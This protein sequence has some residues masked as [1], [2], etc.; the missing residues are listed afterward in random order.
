MHDILLPS[1]RL[2]R[3]RN[4]YRFPDEAALVARV[5]LIGRRVPMR[6]YWR[7][8]PVHLRELPRQMVISGVGPMSERVGEVRDALPPPPSIRS[9]GARGLRR[10]SATAAVAV[11]AAREASSAGASK[12]ASLPSSMPAM[13]AIMRDEGG[14]ALAVSTRTRIRRGVLHRWPIIISAIAGALAAYYAD[15]S[16]GRRRRALMRDR[17]AHMRNVVT[18]TIPRRIE[19]RARFFGGVARGIRHETADFVLHDGHHEQVD[20]DTLV[21]RVRSEAL[22]SGTIKSG[23]INV[24][25]YEGCVTLRGQLEHPGNIRRLVEAVRRVEGVR[26]VRSYLHLPGTLPP[27]KAE[28]Y[29]YA[30]GPLA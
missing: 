8:R 6:G 23:E 26:E 3:L 4:S 2:T 21:A 9:I 14:V 27:N 24:E 20:D 1:N 22:R 12:I 18:R 7:R 16:S 25:A 5:P 29:A 10:A 17:G 28:I 13:P 11:G 30:V 15:P 19:K